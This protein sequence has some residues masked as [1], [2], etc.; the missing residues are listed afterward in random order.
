MIDKVY[1]IC[2]LKGSYMYFLNE[3]DFAK[4]RI[5]WDIN[6]PYFFTDKEFCQLVCDTINLILPEFEIRICDSYSELVELLEWNYME[7]KKD[8]RKPR[9]SSGLS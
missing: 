8:G 5:I 9:C 7:G 6:K 3:F 4:K 1:Y 2:H